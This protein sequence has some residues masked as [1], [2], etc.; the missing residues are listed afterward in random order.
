MK[1]IIYRDNLNRIFTKEERKI[2]IDSV[3]KIGE[4][5]SNIGNAKSKSMRILE[6]TELINIKLFCLSSLKKYTN[7]SSI[8]ISDSWLNYT[9]P[10][11]FLH[12]HNHQNS[13]ISGIFYVNAR[14][15]FHNIVFSEIE[16]T[17]FTD[18]FDLLLFPSHLLHHEPKNIGNDLKISL[19]FNTKKP[20]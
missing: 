11:E 13:L 8:Y 6:N 18:R 14:K 15:L 7:D 1:S 10:G 5:E 2:F 19:S 16:E 12:S 20:I 9:M 17:I 4:I 3:K